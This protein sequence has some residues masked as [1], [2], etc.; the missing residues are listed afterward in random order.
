MLMDVYSIH[1]VTSLVV[2]LVFNGSAVLLMDCCIVNS[3]IV[4]DL[5]SPLLMLTVVSILFRDG[6]GNRG[7]VTST[8][9]VS[10]EVFTPTIV[11][12]ITEE[13]MVTLVVL[14]TST[15]L[16]SWMVVLLLPFIVRGK[17]MEVL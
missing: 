16:P 15:P 11:A 8:G 1:V 2:Q 6:T 12:E 4:S 3:C 9:T 5:A 17:R 10:T 13:P 14:N 7:R